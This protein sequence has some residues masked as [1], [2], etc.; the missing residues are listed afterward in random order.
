[1]I[2]LGLVPNVEALNLP[3]ILSSL[4]DRAKSLGLTVKKWLELADIDESTFY[5]WLNS[6]T[7]PN[8]RSLNRLQAALKKYER[9]KKQA[10]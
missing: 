5:R 4:T 6:E 1:M 10:A 8:L 9:R 2:S 3:E 7:T